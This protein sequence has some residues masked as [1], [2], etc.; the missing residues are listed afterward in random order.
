[1]YICTNFKIM[2]KLFL[3]LFVTIS[4]LTNSA[5]AQSDTTAA[6]SDIP[7][8][9]IPAVIKLAYIPTYYKYGNNATSYS[10]IGD[11]ALTKSQIN[12]LSD[13]ALAAP[14]FYMP[15][16]GSK[17]TA[18]VFVRGVGAR[19]NEPSIGVYVDAIPYVDKHSFNFDFYDIASISLLR[20]PQST[21]FGRNSIGGLVQISTLSPLD[22]QGTKLSILYGNKNAH[23][24]NIAHYAKLTDNVGISF[25]LNES[26]DDG[27][28]TNEFLGTNDKILS[29]GARTRIDWK[30]S[31]TWTAQVT[32]LYDQ[33]RQNAFPYAHFDKNLQ[34]PTTIAYD[35]QGVY[36]RNIAN[37]GLLLSRKT[38]KTI[39]TSATSYQ[40]LNDSLQMDQD[41]TIDSLFRLNQ[42]QHQNS[43]TQEFTWRS[44][45]Y[46]PYSW[47]V[48]AFGFVKTN[49]INAPVTIESS[50]MNI[51]QGHID[52][53]MDEVRKTNPKTPFINLGSQID[54]PGTFNM[55]NYGAAVYHESKL[56]FLRNFTATAGVRLDVE[57]AALDYNSQ[58]ILNT[59]VT[60]AAMPRPAPTKIVLTALGNAHETC[61]NITPK[62][63]LN[64]NISHKANVYATVA[65]GKK[66]GG[67]NYS[68]LSSVFQEK[69][70]SLKAQLKSDTLE[71]A[72]D[73]LYY[74]PESLWNFEVG[75]HFR[76]FKSK[77]TVD[78]AAYYIHYSDM[79]LVST[80]ATGNGSRMIVNAGHSTNF[81]TEF[82]ARLMLAQ[83]L[84]LNVQHGYT[85]ATFGNFVF[86]GNDYSGNYVPFVPRNTLSAG[87]DYTIDIDKK[88][89]NAIVIAAQ[90]SY[91]TNIYFTERNNVQEKFYDIVN[92]TLTFK[93]KVFDYGL[94]V[95]NAFNR[96]Y[97]VFYC[98]SLGNGFA[99]QGKPLQYGFSLSAKF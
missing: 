57:R 8:T 22:F 49:D 5:F 75:S 38:E 87:V 33:T 92:T 55:S 30:M 14:N 41:Y 60:V 63:A 98:E 83:Y 11:S 37:S 85:R 2:Q 32:A 7:L 19:M 59:L 65:Q 48:G 9:K 89:L 80:V 42:T 45:T 78:V 50:M 79:Q 36:D 15:D 39:F 46:K 58:A 56:E 82:S 99:Q 94:W 6:T 21:L 12:N 70:N 72:E 40:H 95:K 31:E 91:Y 43:I 23:R 81:G 74:K 96:K 76:A 84:A 64:Y 34:K 1:M 97:T 3:F 47:I 53:A 71:I 66:S 88:L 27:F 62:F 25:A 18:S 26:G 10:V 13:F 24:Y 93:T 73:K 51:L 68:M 61:V 16:Y 52:A 20:G 90:Y 86:D 29:R 17:G 69:L 54:I 4:L 77:L 28:F 44:N 67:Y 35:N